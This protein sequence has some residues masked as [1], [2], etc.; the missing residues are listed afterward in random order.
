MKILE[1]KWSIATLKC[2][3]QNSLDTLGN[4]RVRAT[5]ERLDTRC[6]PSCERLRIVWPMHFIVEELGKMASLPTGML[7]EIERV[8]SE[9]NDLCK[10]RKYKEAEEMYATLLSGFDQ[11]FV[12]SLLPK[13]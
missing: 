4:R 9:A 3:K 8:T 12:D 1:N 7:Q 10:T 5:N 6:H 11:K 13:E 2:V